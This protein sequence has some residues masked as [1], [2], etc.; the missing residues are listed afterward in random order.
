VFHSSPVQ[1]CLENVDVA[2]PLRVD[3]AEAHT[4]AMQGAIGA[5]MA[6]ESPLRLRIRG[7]RPNGA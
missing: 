3:A 5:P 2:Q 7:V 4:H 1:S 6:K